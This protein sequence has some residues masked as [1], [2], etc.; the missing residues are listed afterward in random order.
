M[1]LYNTTFKVDLNEIVNFRLFLDDF[2]KNLKDE[3]DLFQLLNED[4][5][6]GITYCFQIKFED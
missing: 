4:S 5:L 2:F 1:I 3:T 6:D